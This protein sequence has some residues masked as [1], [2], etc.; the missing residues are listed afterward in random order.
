[1][2]GDR[3]SDGPTNPARVATRARFVAGL[4]VVTVGAAAF[5]VVFRASLAAVYQ[6]LYGADNVVDSI[7][8]LPWW[9]R[10]LVPIGAAALAGGIASLRTERT[11]GV[12][13]V[14]EAIALGRVQLSLRATASRVG[15]SWTAIAGGLSIGRE[16]PLIEVGGA[17]GA[18]I[19]QAF[20]TTLKQTRILVAAGTAAGGLVGLATVP[21]SLLMRAQWASVGHFRFAVTDWREGPAE[22][23]GTVKLT[24]VTNWTRT[25]KGKG[26]HSTQDFKEAWTVDIE[27]TGNAGDPS[28]FGSSAATLEGRARANYT[29]TNSNTGVN[30]VMCNRVI[31]ESTF[32]QVDTGEGSGAG[33]AGISLGISAD[34]QYSIT[35]RPDVT[36]MYKSAYNMQQNN[37]DGTKQCGITT[38]TSSNNSS[39]TGR[40][41]VDIQGDGMI[42]PNHP[43]RLSGTTE[44]KEGDTTRTIT[45]DL[46]RR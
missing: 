29:K 17:L 31:R 3:A 12:S 8:R 37:V 33:T 7:A 14:M 1:M 23:T 36:L 13:N 2:R 24:K 21:I 10:L 6:L 11:Q 18:T 20:G 32:S 16:G 44:E 34:G 45:W 15:S 41:D 39:G 30:L 25:Q 22:W 35:V 27:V 9:L 28:V 19:G 43:D 42:D 40:V 46:H 4:I 26:G 38:T 5:A